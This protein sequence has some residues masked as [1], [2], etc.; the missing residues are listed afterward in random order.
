MTGQVLKMRPRRAEEPDSK[1]VDALLKSALEYAPF[2]V[3]IADNT[4][5]PLYVNR[6]LAKW[7][8]RPL[9]QINREPLAEL[10]HHGDRAAF[11]CAMR[12]ALS[13]QRFY[14]NIEV[15]LRAKQ[16][17]WVTVSLSTVAHQGQHHVIVHF[18]D[19]TRRRLQQKELVKLARRDH[20]TGL[21]N[22]MAFEENLRR[23]VKN[24]QRHHRTGAVLYVDLDDFKGIND[25]F[26]HKV[27]DL[28]LQRVARVLEKT[29][30]ETDTVARIGGDEFAIIMDEADEKECNTKVTDIQV[31]VGTIRVEI[32]GKHVI[33]QA[34]VGCQPFDG[35]TDV[36]LDTLL[37]NAD[38]AMYRHKAT[39][40]DRRILNS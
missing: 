3:C 16:E 24:A 6:Q 18:T 25:T 7:I 1:A 23:T 13:G 35:R 34:S 22:R 8:D 15:R 21:E 33:P 5:V 2:G 11:A 31:A 38:Q 29:F 28:I 19:V 37:G 36:C 30:R 26:G 14:R 10:I 4:G 32:D 12:R 27:G 39:S 17:R 40:K 9:Q 20:L